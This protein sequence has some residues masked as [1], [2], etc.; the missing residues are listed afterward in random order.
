MITHI[1]ENINE[2]QTLRSAVVYS[3][4]DWYP[5]WKPQHQTS[6]IGM[7]AWL[8]SRGHGFKSR[9][10]RGLQL[11]IL[12]WGCPHVYYSGDDPDVRTSFEPGFSDACGI[13]YMYFWVNPK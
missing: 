13:K 3:T 7:G 11:C 4:D 10:R 1:G 9:V 8:Q 5:G 12:F 6:L 2:I